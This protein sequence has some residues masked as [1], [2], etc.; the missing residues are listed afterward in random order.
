MSWEALL[1][2]LL[3]GLV[4]SMNNRVTALS[5]FAELAAM[6]DEV[7]DTQ[8]LRQEIKRL[9]GVSAMVGILATRSEEREA[10]ELSGVLETALGIHEHHTRSRTITCRVEKSGML[11]P[12]RVPRWALLRV[13]L[14]MVD[15]AKG[16]ADAARTASTIMEV[17][18]D[19]AFVRVYGG[20]VHAPADDAVTY[21]KLCGGE[22][23][24]DPRGQVLVLPSLL[25]V[26]RRERANT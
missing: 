1:E 20:A 26:R 6:D 19:E 24:A 21:A 15:A 14:L 23:L 11:L 13:L 12:V 17:A 3:R 22:L 18:G 2:E 10:L 25:E 8:M 9:H 16:A 7:P 4:H 5:A